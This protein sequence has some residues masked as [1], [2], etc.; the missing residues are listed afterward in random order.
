MTTNQEP[1]TANQFK[2]R[3]ANRDL[4]LGTM[5]T[6]D[7]P[8]IVELLASL[9][10]EW[11]FIDG[12]H[13][14][15]SRD[16]IQRLVRAAGTTPCLVRTP[17]GEESH[18]KNVLDCGAAGVIVPM[19]N[20]AS[21]ARDVVAATKY[22]PLGKRGVGVS[23][24]HGY[25]QKFQDY[26]DSAND[27]TIVVVQAEHIEAVHNIE[28]ILKVPGIDCVLVGPYDLSASMG[29]IGQ[30]DHEEVMDA[31]NTIR[32]ACLAVKM[33]L[34]YF[35]VSAAAIQPYIDQGFSL[36]TAG[37]DTIHLAKSARV[38]IEELKH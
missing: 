14:P 11:L 30:V 28:S 33:P 15:F 24:A 37:V 22:P 3:L 38:I 35:G 5:V 16:A 25:G 29:K 23:R 10:F 6:L 34:G 31:I 9:D 21:Q 19:V 32:D 26:V 2:S 12:E 4:L 1:K 36:I 17:S 8:E 20:S 13:A 7:S 18:I 27:E